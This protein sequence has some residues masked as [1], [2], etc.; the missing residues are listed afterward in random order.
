MSTTPETPGPDGSGAD[1]TQPAGDAVPQPED[2]Q[3][4]L[5]AAASPSNTPVSDPAG[6]DATVGERADPALR[7]HG[8]R[9]AD[10]R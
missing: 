9:P 10:P 4:T 2:R 6:D 8:P 1:L 3:S 7:G 5:D